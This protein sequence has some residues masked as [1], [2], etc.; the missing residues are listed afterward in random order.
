MSLRAATEGQ[1]KRALTADAP[2]LWRALRAEREDDARY[3][4]S[5]A[6]GARA[7]L[8]QVARA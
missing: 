3:W 1:L 5:D 2:Q 7:L 4:V 6:E 8:L